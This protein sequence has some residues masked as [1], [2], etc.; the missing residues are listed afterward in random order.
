MAA[1]TFEMG[2]ILTVLIMAIA[3]GM[4]AFSLGFGI[5]MRGIRLFHMLRISF[6]IGLF[7]VLMPLAGMAMGKYAGLLLGDI[8]VMAGGL[9]LILL[10]VHM[11][12]QSLVSDQQT[13]WFDYRTTWGVF[14]IALSVSV[15][16]FSVGVSLGLIA[17][18]IFLVIL[19]FGAFGGLMSICGLILGRKVSSWL[20]VYGE[21]FGGII[22]LMFGLKFVV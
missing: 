13:A 9:L 10:G 14:A 6:I 7:H 3:L 16:S 19:L 17:T 11:L 8:A 1:T 15:D 20:G 12:Y 22:L 2:H 18:N 4:D 21:A 5:G